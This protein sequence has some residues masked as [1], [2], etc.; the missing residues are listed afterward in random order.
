M[1][2]TDAW[3][4][5]GAPQPWNTVYSIGAITAIEPVEARICIRD[6]Q[7]RKVFTFAVHCG[8]LVIPHAREHSEDI[9]L[10]KLR[11][12]AE[13]YRHDMIIK[14]AEYLKEHP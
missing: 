2:I 8:D 14:W 10:E 6:Q 11:G 13:M 7:Q 1:I 3:T 9:P 5:D 12:E 4:I